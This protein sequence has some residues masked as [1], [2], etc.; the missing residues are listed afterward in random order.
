[1]RDGGVPK[2]GLGGRSCR[3][4][5]EERAFQRGTPVVYS[6]AVRA[7][8]LVADDQ[9][10]VLEALRFLLKGADLEAD[11]VTSPA[12]ALGRLQAQP[13]ELLLADLNYT[14]DTTSAGE[15]LDL[16]SRAR[17]LDPHLPVVVMTGWGTIDTA[18]EA[19]RRGARSFVQKPWNNT[20]LLEILAREI[21]DGRAARQQNVR[22]E[23]EQADARAIQRG[24]LPPTLPCIAP[25]GIAAAWRPASGYGGDCYDALTFD[26]DVLGLLIADVAGK[27]LPAALLMSNLQAAVRAF[28]E[29]AAP[30]SEVCAKVN[31]L[32][33]RHMV[34]GRFITACYL[35]LDCRRHVLTC[36]NA[37]HNPPL[38]VRA[39]G[40][41]VR[42][43]TGGTVLGVFPDLTYDQH[44]V[45]VGRGDRLV[46]YTDGITEATS[47]EGDEYGE[48]RLA[49]AIAARAGLDAAALTSALFDDVLT[50]AS[51]T[52]HD[53]ATIMSVVVAP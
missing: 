32:L 35:R 23:R 6:P 48:E 38:L 28:S 22:H 10:D 42:L 2:V 3:N 31:R 39:S 37:G 12:A 25:Y 1:M 50:F 5:R 44:H 15:G 18:V 7:R 4:S 9:A 14:R 26:E 16:V 19:M 45:D 43:A 41:V 11:F 20:T 24:L 17:G 34:S 30:P 29:G 53:D 21:E 51:E 40:E 52:L 13:Y 49:S 46:L 47:P 8:V 36:A 27:G 33:C